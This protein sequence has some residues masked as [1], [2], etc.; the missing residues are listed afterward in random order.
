[1]MGHTSIEEW[2]ESIKLDL[3]CDDATAL[4]HILNDINDQLSNFPDILSNKIQ[5]QFW[6][7]LKSQVETI[8]GGS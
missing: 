5:Y 6:V 3:S 1:M 8:I 4:N 7:D 2:K